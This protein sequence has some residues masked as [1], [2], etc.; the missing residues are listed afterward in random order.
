MSFSHCK[1]S[2]LTLASNGQVTSTKSSHKVTKAE[3]AATEPEDEWDIKMEFRT[4]LG[5]SKPVPPYIYT[6]NHIYIG[7]KC[8]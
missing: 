7:Y 4:Q 8:I 1:Q 2:G 3:V 5:V 6:H